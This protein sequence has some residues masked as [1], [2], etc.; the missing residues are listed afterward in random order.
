[1]VV[2]DEPSGTCDIFEVPFLPHAS[3]CTTPAPDGRY[4]WYRMQTCG[5][6]YQETRRTLSWEA[7]IRGWHLLR[8]R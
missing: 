6:A 4:V 3:F 1:M 7:W 8:E 5:G 2:Y